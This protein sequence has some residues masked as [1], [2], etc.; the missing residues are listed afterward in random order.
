M[1]QSRDTLTGITVATDTRGIAT[2]TLDR[3]DIHNAFDDAMIAALTRALHDL[4]AEA[5]HDLR[6][7]PPLPEVVSVTFSFRF[8]RVWLYCVSYETS[9]PS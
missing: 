6:Q 2:V 5:S 9:V 1:A 8:F 3:P 4:D 7:P